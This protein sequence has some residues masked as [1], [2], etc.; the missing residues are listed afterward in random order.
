MDQPRRMK[1]LQAIVEDY[2]ASREPVG[3]KALV[4]RHNLGVSSAT[5]RNDMAELED[6]GLIAAPHT[7]S[8]RIPTDKGYRYFVDRISE[9]RPLSI[10]EKR[11]VQRLLDN[12]DGID[13]MMAATVQ[14]LSQLTRQVAVIQ[15]PHMDSSVIRRVEFVLLSEDRMLAVLILSTGRVDQ[16]V[17]YLNEVV[18]QPTLDVLAQVFM[19]YLDNVSPYNLSQALTDVQ[20]A[21]PQEHQ[22]LVCALGNAVELLAEA[23]HRDRILMAGTA[24]LARS[25]QD[26]SHS[27]GPILEALEEQVVLLKLLTEMEN[28][29]HGL[30]VRIGDENFGSLGDTS[31]VAAGYG[32]GDAA[33]IGVVGPTRMDY[34]S[35]M[36]AVRAIARYLSRILSS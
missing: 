36:S 29:V 19:K 15:Y 4:E 31:V 14:V 32:P 28:D 5:V 33:K 1:V 24:N 20:A 7:S 18:D 22:Q 2:V 27:I 25:P 21:V 34:P 8:G 12:S 9:V 11:A 35:T 30:S 23:G 26:F 10:A 16:R 13:D 3:S 17:V 6:E